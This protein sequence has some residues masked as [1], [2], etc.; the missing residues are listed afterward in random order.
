MK[1]MRK[2]KK[3]FEEF[4]TFILRGNIVELA[5][6]VIIGGAF[7]GLVTSLLD[8]IISPIIGCF[9]VGGFNNI[10]VKIWN[11][12]LYIGAFITDV[13]NFLIMALVVFLM[14]KGVMKLMSLAKKEK[15]TAP[16]EPSKEEVLLTEIRDLLKEQNKK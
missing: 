9:N 8:N 7:N 13:V 2:M 4:K 11:A 10:H 14:L 5:I 3:F 6:G 1:G 12:N 15:E 16:P